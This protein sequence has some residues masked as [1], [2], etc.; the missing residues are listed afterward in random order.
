MRPLS[1]FC[2]LRICCQTSP[3]GLHLRKAF[4]RSQ[5][6]P[7]CCG[8]DCCR[9]ASAHHQFCM[10]GHLCCASISI[11]KPLS[12]AVC[13]LAEPK[14]PNFEANFRRL[15][16]RSRYNQP[17]EDVIKAVVRLLAARMIA[18]SNIDQAEDLY[19]DASLLPGASTVKHLLTQ[20]NLRVNGPLY[21]RCEGRQ[22]ASP[23]GCLDMQE[24]DKLAF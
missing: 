11:Q 24:V 14:L 19:H 7:L 17:K 18:C 12:N 21:L 13:S 2:G 6:G 8:C 22:N 16:V 15:L 1:L 4:E 9:S 23:F 5:C 3:V 20:H 10:T